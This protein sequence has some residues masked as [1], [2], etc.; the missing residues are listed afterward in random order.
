MRHLA[1]G[2]VA[3]GHQVTI[4]GAGP[5]PPGRKLLAPGVGYVPVP[6]WGGK[7][8]RLLTYAL[9][10]RGLLRQAKVELIFS[11]ERTL[12]QHVYR[13][14]DGCHRE[15]LARRAATLDPWGRLAYRLSPFHR[16][17]LWLE[18]KLFAAPEL[19]RVIANSRMVREELIHHFQVPPE[20]IRLVYNGLDHRRFHPLSE[21]ERRAWRRRLGAGEHVGLVLFVGSGFQ[22]KGLPQ[23]L[24]AFAGLSDKSAAMWVVGQDRL[25]RFQKLAR[26]L[27]VADR[28]RFWGPKEEVTPFYQ[29]A[30][31]LA[32]PTLYDPLSNVV[33]EALGCGLPVLTTPAN[34]AAEFIVPGTNGEI[35]EPHRIPAWTAALKAW[36][37]R[38]RDP[39]VKEAAQEA[40]A[41]LS[42]EATVARTLEVLE[43]AASLR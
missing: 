13:A 36:L 23:L 22:R 43:E 41:G 20:K 32:L 31:L 24:E 1:P 4:Y 6:V 9:N 30:S 29:A 25:S 14:G 28:V 38:S 27:G 21:G 8:G 26:R 12:Y 42:W 15:W 39:K 3:A 7:T 2:L 37:E 19:T 10:A 33:L 18:A 5:K 40:V 11:L 17:L 16:V 35:L 34:G